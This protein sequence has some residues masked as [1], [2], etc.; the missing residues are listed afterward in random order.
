M[1]ELIAP[2]LPQQTWKVLHAILHQDPVPFRVHREALQA[3][4][5]ALAAAQQPPPA[6]APKPR[7]GK[8]AK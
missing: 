8:A 2:K 1:S 4:E 3:L 6:P 5:A 7:R